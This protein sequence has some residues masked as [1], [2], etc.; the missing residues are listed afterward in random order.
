[1]VKTLL[2][3]GL[4]RSRDALLCAALRGAGVAV[5]QLPAPSDAGLR[6][7]RAFGNH[8]QCSP[9]HYAVGA[10]LEAAEASG[11]SGDT[12]ARTHRWVTAGSCGPCRLAA[13]PLEWA[14]VLGAQGLSGLELEL[15][16]Q[17]AFLAAFEARA[18][19]RS[20][21]RVVLAALVAGDVFSA[22]ERALRPWVADEARLEAALDRG[23]VEV[24]TALER[25]ASVVAPLRTLGVR[26]RAIPG[27]AARVVPR[28]L[29][30][31]EPWSTLAEGDPCD[32]VVRRL[33]AAGAEVEVPRMV[34]W[35]QTQAWQRSVEPSCEA[36]E[37]AVCHRAIRG[38][39]ALWRLLASAA[40]VFEPLEAP[41]ALAARATPFYPPSIRGGSAHLEV[42]RALGAMERRAVHLVLSVKPFGCLPSSALSDGVLAPL[43]RR[44]PGAPAFAVLEANATG[45]ATV[46]SRLELALERAT[47]AA[48]EEFE[49]AFT[50]SG[51]TLAEARSMLSPWPR[52]L[53]GPRR[54]A[55]SAAERLARAT[56]VSGEDRT[57]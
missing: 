1:M 11:L 17:R 26:A 23:L 46:D 37:R 38:L 4:G 44:T 52:G 54:Y 18:L 57:R 16:D 21:G 10:V 22:L 28:V 50:A 13:F 45:Q 36:V 53:E 40:G 12:F 33:E 42:A 56:A 15:I 39:A 29:L 6:R 35:L 24:A 55:C 27:D 19:G 3:G 51:L 47:L 34:E 32:D 49:H 48:V 41:A 9:A 43:L 30:V 2:V 14:K 31:G 5:R 20:P 8:G 25:G 7:A